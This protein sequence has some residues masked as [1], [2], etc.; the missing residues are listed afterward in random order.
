MMRFQFSK[1]TKLIKYNE[2]CHPLRK[3]KFSTN[4]N[5][6]IIQILITWLKSLVWYK[7]RNTIEALSKLIYVYICSSNPSQCNE[8]IK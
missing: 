1:Y 2:Y 4:W 7:N 8:V 5:H 6:T 3:S